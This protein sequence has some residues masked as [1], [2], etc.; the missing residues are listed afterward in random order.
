MTL[1]KF[2]IDVLALLKDYSQELFFNVVKIL[3]QHS[4]LYSSY[5]C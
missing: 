1:I 5:T 2:L 4:P 3:L